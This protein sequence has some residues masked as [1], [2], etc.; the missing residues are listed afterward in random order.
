MGEQ[1]L[2]LPL[3]YITDVFEGAQQADIL[4]T[5]ADW[6]SHE[7]RL[8]WAREEID[9][10]GRFAGM[11]E[12]IIAHAAEVLAETLNRSERELEADAA[13][14]REAGRRGRPN[15]FTSFE[16]VIV[17]C[18]RVLI[19]MG[20][21]ADSD[22]VKKPR[23]NR[24]ARLAAG[25]LLDLD[26]WASLPSY[27]RTWPDV[28]KQAERAAAGQM[29]GAQK[30]HAALRKAWLAAPGMTE[31]AMLIL[32]R[33]ILNA[34]GEFFAFLWRV[35]IAAATG[36]GRLLTYIIGRPDEYPDYA[37]EY[38]RYF[39]ALQRIAAYAGRLDDYGVTLGAHDRATLRSA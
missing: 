14:R 18:A 26:P 24:A 31:E 4:P 39:L 37:E 21:M 25:A 36:Q 28:C 30:Q 23:R 10:K 34:A 8:R 3:A 27:K 29:R 6:G 16:A 13:E 12:S 22:G 5:L 2:T 9:R 38:D 7:D 20:K 17:N 11:P 19:Q 1:R 32:D 35:R 33:R 15:R